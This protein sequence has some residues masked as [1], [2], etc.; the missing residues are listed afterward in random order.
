[1]GATLTLTLGLCYLLDS[2][3]ALPPGVAVRGAL[4]PVDPETVQLFFDRT[5]WDPERGERVIRQ[6]VFDA[7]LDMI[8]AAQRYVV[9][10]FFLW[11]TWQGAEPEEHRRLATQLAE[12]LIARKKAVPDLAVLVISDPINRVY[13]SAQE[14]FFEAMAEAG[15]PVVFTDLDRLPDSNRIYAPPARRIGRLFQRSRVISRWIARPRWPNPLDRG[16]AP[17]ST[18]QMGRL[19]FFKANHRKVLITDG[20]GGAPHLLVTSMNPADGSS[21]HDNLGLRVS[22]AVAEEAL[23]TELACAAWSAKRAANVLQAK[24]G[25]WQRVAD[26]IR[27]RITNATAPPATDAGQARVAWDT[28]GAIRRRLLKMI[29]N[30]G[31]GDQLMGM[32]FYLSD[33]GIV[34]ALQS[35]AARGARVRLILDPNKDAFGFKKN[36]VPNRP[37]AAELMRAA[38]TRGL[39]L[40][41]R[42]AATH[43]E[44]FHAKALAL[45][46]PQTGTAAMSVGSAN[47]T[48]RNLQNF[49]LEANLY[50]ENAPVALAVYAREFETA[51]ANQDGLLHTVAYS[52]LAEAWWATG[53]KTVLYRFQERFG[54]GTF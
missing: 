43:G 33:R 36:G 51:W 35:A 15:I 27:Q 20:P 3:P 41:I 24:P 4:H 52:D 5:A 44:Q 48:R 32:T 53:Y 28:E 8:A 9:A 23:Q 34:D 45:M 19:L 17:V 42:W 47:W 49:N 14:P 29:G 6:E 39:P 40:E 2:Q 26:T 7:V 1:M 11:N 25:E 31:P 12:A 50:V 21:A 30:A 37:V 46:N 18:G 54:A 38:R 22:G 13:G 16:G 10:D